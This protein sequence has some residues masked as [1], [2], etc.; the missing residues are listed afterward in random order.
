MRR[1]PEVRQFSF[2]VR[3]EKCVQPRWADFVP[4][5]RQ[6]SALSIALEN[7]LVG[8]SPGQTVALYKGDWCLGGGTIA[9][10]HTLADEST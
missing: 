6:G 7:P 5:R 4:T 10:T 8:V 2:S 9:S 3:Q 1:H